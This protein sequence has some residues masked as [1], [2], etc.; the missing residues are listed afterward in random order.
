MEAYPYVFKNTNEDYSFEKFLKVTTLISSRAFQVDAY[1]ENALVP[2]ADLFNH[3][4]KEHVHFETEFDV[5][6]ACGVLEYCEHQYLDMLE[7]DEERE[8]MERELLENG[9]ADEDE[10]IVEGEG[11]EDIEDESDEE[12]E[13]EEDEMEEMDTE[14]PDL[15]E[16]E[17]A[18]VNF[19]DSASSDDTKIDTCDMILDRDVLKNEEVFNT[20]GD[21]PNIALLSKYGF[22]FDDNKNDYVSVSEDALVDC[23][24]ALTMENMKRYE[25]DDAQLE[26]RA[27]Q[28]TGPRY[29]FFL[30]HEQVLCPSGEDSDDE[31]EEEHDDYQ[32]EED[33]CQDECCSPGDEEHSHHDHTEEGEE[34]EHDEEGGCCGGGDDEHSQVSRPYYINSEGLF[35]DKVM[36]LLHIMFVDQD[37]FESFTKDFGNALEYFE[38][39]SNDKEAS[40]KNKTKKLNETKRTVYQLC[41]ALVDLRRNDYLDEND[42]WK[43]ISEEIKE[44][45]KVGILFCFPSSLVH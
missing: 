31:E 43:T 17:E 10:E 20:Y 7:S 12:E 25:K 21:H 44:R 33:A 39:L 15:E 16:L 11:E 3:D 4:Q 18:G 29:S 37:T 1:H 34:H 27:V 5:C 41:H 13:E 26:E 40:G 14:L 19:W 45:K 35:E 22:C 38:A 30:E 28:H 24:I 6:D 2:F 36:C 9:D 23:C 32:E 42:E 8:E